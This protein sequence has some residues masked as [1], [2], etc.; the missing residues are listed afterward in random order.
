MDHGQIISV[1]INRALTMKPH[2]GNHDK[3]SCSPLR[4]KDSPKSAFAAFD[5]I[6]TGPAPPCF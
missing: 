5:A 4:K 1:P 6:A 3:S 2:G